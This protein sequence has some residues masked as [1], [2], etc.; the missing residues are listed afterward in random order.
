MT[1]PHPITN[2]IKAVYAADDSPA[3]LQCEANNANVWTDETDGT[4]WML[5][6]AGAE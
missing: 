1:E 2:L 5:P 3:C 6:R 4:I